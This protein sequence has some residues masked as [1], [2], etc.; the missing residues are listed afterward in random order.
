MLAVMAEA[1]LAV[2]GPSGYTGTLVVAEARALGL[3]LRLV[4]RRRDALE[5]MAAAWDELRVA[6]ARDER[7]LREA[8][9]GAF[10]VAP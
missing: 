9:D 5:A 6:D 3:P 2:L 7:A 10:A 4:A 1:P 8:F